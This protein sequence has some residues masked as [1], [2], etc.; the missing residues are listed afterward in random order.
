LTAVVFTNNG[1]YFTLFCVFHKILF[2]VKTFLILI[3]YSRGWERSKCFYLLR[4]WR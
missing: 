3:P 2:D 4:E 1:Y